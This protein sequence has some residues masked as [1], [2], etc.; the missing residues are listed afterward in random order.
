MK[1][2]TVNYW[3]LVSLHCGCITCDLK[4]MLRCV[5]D[6]LFLLWPVCA[7]QQ[8]KADMPS[9]PVS[10][11]RIQVHVWWD[12]SYRV[13]SSKLL[14]PLWEYCLHFG[15]LRCWYKRTQAFQSCAWLW[16]GDTSTNHN[17]LLFVNCCK[18]EILLCGRTYSEKFICRYT[19]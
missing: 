14:L 11:W 19:N 5:I 2:Y 4:T 9:P 12:T 3:S 10:S 6:F 17:T 13:V 18:Y 7:H 8:F 15:F 1:E 16:Q